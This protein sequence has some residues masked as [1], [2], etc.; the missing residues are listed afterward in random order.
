MVAKKPQRQQTKTVT[1]YDFNRAQDN[2]AK[3]VA[4]IQG[5]SLQ[6]VD[7]AP[8]GFKSPGS[9]GQMYLSPDDGTLW[10]C[11]APNAWKVF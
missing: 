3:T 5:T 10:I 1:G 4:E 7:R 8:A 6:F 2:I 9:R 11:Y